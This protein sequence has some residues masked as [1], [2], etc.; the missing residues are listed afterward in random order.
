MTHQLPYIP[1][2]TELNR[3]GAQGDHDLEGS[4]VLGANLLPFVKQH[5][6][7]LEPRARSGNGLLYVR[8]MQAAIRL[9]EKRVNHAS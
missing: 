1:S 4:I 9:G 6:A 3:R 7:R 5:L 2:V 8:Q